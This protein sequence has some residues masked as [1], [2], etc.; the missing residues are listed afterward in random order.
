MS[1]VTRSHS[2]STKMLAHARKHCPPHCISVSSILKSGTERLTHFLC[3]SSIK[4]DT[5]D[6]KVWQILV[7]DFDMLARTGFTVDDVTWTFVLLILKTDEEARC[8]SFGCVSWASAN[9]VCPDCLAD[10]TTRPYTD[11]RSSAAWR[12][13]LVTSPEDFL[14]RNRQPDH[15]L[16]ASAFATRHLMQLDIMH[17]MDCK[18]VSSIVFGSM[19]QY[20]VQDGRLGRNQGERLDTFNRELAA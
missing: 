15:P 14:R 7:R 18:G 12:N 19:L 3:A 2:Q 1:S 4:K 10:R 6:L 17:C 8:N 11:L 5:D 20:V 9:E 13:H 16:V